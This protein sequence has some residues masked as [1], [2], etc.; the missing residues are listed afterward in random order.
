MFDQ[1]CS[2][3]RERQTGRLAICCVSIPPWVVIAGSA[4]SNRQCDYR[5]WLVHFGLARFLAAIPTENAENEAG[6][7][8]FV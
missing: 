7:A 8:A 6:G 1:A 3:P 2:L 5:G 4:F